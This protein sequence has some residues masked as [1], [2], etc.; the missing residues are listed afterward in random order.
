[1]IGYRADHSTCGGRLVALA[2]TSATVMSFFAPPHLRQSACRCPAAEEAA[3]T[4][5]HAD[6]RPAAFPGGID[7][8]C[9][10][11]LP[12]TRCRFCWAPDQWNRAHHPLKTWGRNASA[13]PVAHAVPGPPGASPVATAVVDSAQPW[14]GQSGLGGQTSSSCGFFGSTDT[15]VCNRGAGRLPVPGPMPPLDGGDHCRRSPR[16]MRQTARQ[17]NP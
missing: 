6:P 12:E 11:C 4:P 13:A 17:A 3:L 15:M 2:G 16:R 9:L 8:V 10:G 1:M 14:H 7:T 5:C